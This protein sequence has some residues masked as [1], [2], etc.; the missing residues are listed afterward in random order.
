MSG[1]SIDAIDAVLCEFDEEGRPRGVLGTHSAPYPDALRLELLDLQRRPDGAITLR[2]FARLDGAVGDRFALAANALLRK[3]QVTPER[4][5]AIG[6]HGQTVFHDPNGISTSLQ[7]GDPNRIAAQTGILTV[8]DFRRADMARGG[9][10]AP[11]VP[12]FHHAVFAA[13]EHA[14]VVLNIGGIANLTILPGLHG[15]AASGFDTGPGNALLDEW[16]QRCK[17]EA[18]DRDG[19]WAASGQVLAPLLSACLT[20]PYFAAAAPKSTG[21]DHF[22]LDWL[23]ARFPG[24]AACAAHD[25]QRTLL[26]LSIES[27]GRAIELIARPGTIELF[28]CGGGARNARM[29]AG[30]ATRLPRMQVRTTEHLGVD[31]AWV[32]ASAFAWLAWQTVH[33]RPGNLPAVTGASRAAVLGGLY[34]V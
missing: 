23:F 16:I 1:T 22:N 31:P 12:A 24:L 4:I 15:E 10:G 27:I 17:G 11:L 28:V 21:R 29:M 8:S 30:L 20:D 3:L 18:Y 19:Q 26:E 14:R 5:C 2:D 7:I 32:E 6:S 25:V 33:G 9:Q 13:S 34:K